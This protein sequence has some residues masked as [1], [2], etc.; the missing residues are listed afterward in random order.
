MAFK[1]GCPLRQP[2]VFFSLIASPWIWMIRLHYGMQVARL[3][4]ILRLGLRKV[5]EVRR[6]VWV[7]SS[8]EMWRS[9]PI[10]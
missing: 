1:R 8:L 9:L 5:S 3:Y 4:C 6:M 10:S 2:L 7:I